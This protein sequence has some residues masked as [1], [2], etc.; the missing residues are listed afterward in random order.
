MLP[1]HHETLTASPAV[2]SRQRQ[3]SAEICEICGSHR[4]HS[5]INWF[6]AGEHLFC[7]SKSVQWN[8]VADFEEL[9]PH[10][11][12]VRIFMG[13]SDCFLRFPFRHFDDRSVACAHDDRRA[14]S[15]ES[16]LAQSRNAIS[17]KIEKFRL[18]LRLRPIRHNH[19]YAAHTLKIHGN[20]SGKQENRKE[21]QAR[22]SKQR[23]SIQLTESIP[24][25]NYQVRRR[26]CR[27]RSLLRRSTGYCLLRRLLRRTSR[28]S[29]E[30]DFPR[31]IRL[32]YPCGSKRADLHSCFIEHGTA[33]ES[34]IASGVCY[35]ALGLPAERCD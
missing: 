24:I 33:G 18:S 17:H 27:E 22:E 6:E 21:F 20:L 35:N 13:G 16:L 9:I 25:S 28:A 14:I 2:G 34:Q 12:H 5:V 15:D 11:E 4:I 31:A 3:L 32:S 29:V 30:E 26:I 1:N 19:N 23:S 8:G 10:C 7:F